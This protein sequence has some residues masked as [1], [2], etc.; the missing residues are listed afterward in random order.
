MATRTAGAFVMKSV[1]KYKVGTSATSAVVA[2]A[3]D[4]IVSPVIL[5]D[6]G[7]KKILVGV[8][9][10]VAF[11]N[12]GAELDVEGS[13]DGTNWVALAEATSDILEDATGVKLYLVDLSSIRA[14]YYRLKVNNDGA[15][16][17]TTGTLKFIYAVEVEKS[18]VAS[19]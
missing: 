2:G 18:L 3:T 8:N 17:N 11:D 7:D 16:I 4:N 1:N 12:V 5:D 10:I 15:A 19:L 13:T 6:L 9:V 14:P